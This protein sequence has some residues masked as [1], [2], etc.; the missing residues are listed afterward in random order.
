MSTSPHEEGSQETWETDWNH[1]YLARDKLR[2]RADGSASAAFRS[3]EHVLQSHD[4]V[5]NRHLR[6]LT[7]GGCLVKRQHN[8][9]KPTT[10]ALYEAWAERFI[11]LVLDDARL[12]NIACQRSKGLKKELVEGVSMIERVEA[13]A[14][15]VAISNENVCAQTGKGLLLLDLCSGKG[16]TAVLLALRFHQAKVVGLDIRPPSPT[17]HHLHQGFLPNF[18]RKTG[19]LYDDN[20]LDEI[21]HEEIPPDGTGILLGT[22][23]CGDLSRC[24]LDLMGRH[25]NGRIGAAVI[26]PCCL[27]R[28][29]A[30]LGSTTFS[31]RAWGYD[32][33]RVARRHAL[34]PFGLWLGR[35]ERRAP[36]SDQNKTLLYDPDM[37][38]SKN[39]YLLLCQSGLGHL[40]EQNVLHCH[41]VSA[42]SEQIAMCPS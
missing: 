9:N 18:V 10:T 30:P 12:A 8:N 39:V 26:V 15:Q 22:H 32:T 33:A 1:P 24:A 36:V 11:Q 27:Q 40:A 2:F 7:N 28:Q 37:L 29:K 41:E 4:C 3:M 23:L 34:D 21:I 16:I 42:C 25:N 17:E 5:T 38:S 31:G 19:N 14:K 6:R 20:L 35:L 13:I